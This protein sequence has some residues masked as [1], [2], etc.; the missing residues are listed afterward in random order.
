MT[1]TPGILTGWAR[2]HR[3]GCLVARPADSGEAAAIVR[4]C[5]ERGWTI[6]P[7][8][9]GCS[10][11]GNALNDGN[12]VLDTGGLDR[13]IG[14]DADTG[15]VTA[16]AGVS[17]ARIVDLA[18]PLGWVP[19]GV[20]GS[21]SVT[22]GGAIGNN[23][24]G[25]DSFSAGPFGNAVR[26]VAVLEA[27]GEIRHYTPADEAFRHIIGGFGLLGIVVE[28]DIQ[29]RKVRGPMVE[30]RVVAFRDLA[31][32][33]D[34]FETH[35]GDT[36]LMLGW[37]DAFS[38]Q[39]RGSLELGNFVAAPAGRTIPPVAGRPERFFGL[40]P[41]GPIYPVARPLMSGLVMRAHNEA[42]YRADKGGKTSCV[43]FGS[44]VF[45]LAFTVPDVAALFP[46]GLI[47][48]Q[49]LIPAGGAV[50]THSAILALCRDHGAQSWLCSAKRC[51]ADGFPLSFAGDGISLSI[52]IPG[53]RARARDFEA[54]YRRLVDT[55]A[56][57]GG[58]INLSKDE[59]MRPHD[60]RRLYPGL[61]PFLAF[62]AR[63]DPETRFS[64]DFHRRLQER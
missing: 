60:I 11:T 34:L 21:P 47:E 46:G 28:A 16:E 45:P 32:L 18:L 30:S 51:S 62:K 55:V 19:G 17:L 27:D 10:Y 12:V 44:H 40:L 50:A 9:H 54:F 33:A 7:R 36:D 2:R 61:D 26:R 48:A 35:R 23:V 13:I 8:G 4:S 41:P 53:R 29:L 39:G 64:S 1:L 24:H 15:I 63:H 14:F 5:A 20:P 42:K 25:K 59:F 3:A 43:D 31:E 57:A 6:V 38:P 49:V 37:V 56:E 58:L 22:V 52:C